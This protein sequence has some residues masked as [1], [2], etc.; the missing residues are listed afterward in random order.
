MTTENICRK[1]A[2]RMVATLLVAGATLCAV[3]EEVKGP[4]RVRDSWYG[5]DRRVFEFRGREA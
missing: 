5:F 1:S 4:S 3:G 2:M